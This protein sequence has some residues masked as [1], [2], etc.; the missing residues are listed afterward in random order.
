M[1]RQLD[2][3]QP[4]SS[5]CCDDE[6][7]PSSSPVDCPSPDACK[8]SIPAAAAAAQQPPAKPPR[9][10]TSL[11]SNGSLALD[12]SLSLSRSISSP[13]DQSQPPEPD[14]QSLEPQPPDQVP[15]GEAEE[16]SE[17][18]SPVLHSP[19]D[20]QPVDQQAPE[21]DDVTG[22]NDVTVAAATKERKKSKKHKKKHRENE[23]PE[24]RAARKLEK[25]QKKE[26]KLQKSM[27]ALLGGDCNAPNGVGELTVV[28]SPPPSVEESV[29]LCISGLVGYKY[30]IR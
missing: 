24:E 13:Q 12:T 22:N 29:S 26:L 3:V 7:Q 11:D 14:Q 17:A 16:A 30:Y 25:K 9:S 28:E 6:Q 10:F 15:T 23:T 21:V 1:M 2:M 4:A 20:P 8:D 19:P 5:D 27:T 18:A